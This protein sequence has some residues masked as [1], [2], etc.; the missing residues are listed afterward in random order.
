MSKFKVGDIVRIIGAE[1]SLI[2]AYPRV[3]VNKSAMGDMV[4]TRIVETK[5]VSP[6]AGD[7]GKTINHCYVDIERCDG[8]EFMICIPNSDEDFT[9]KFVTINEDDLELIEDRRM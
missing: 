2:F 3:I 1:S 8:K 4:V 9:S 7:E 6:F 5:D